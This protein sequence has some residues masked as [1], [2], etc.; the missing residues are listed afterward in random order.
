MILGEI[1]RQ[2]ASVAIGRG[3]CAG[4][5]EWTI[6]GTC[7]RCGALD[8]ADWLVYA[9]EHGNHV[10][11]IYSPTQETAGRRAIAEEL[12]ATLRRIGAPDVEIRRL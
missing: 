10:A 11:A 2:S 9:D 1:G 7:T 8:T 6:N 4:P 3:I 12:N 5:H